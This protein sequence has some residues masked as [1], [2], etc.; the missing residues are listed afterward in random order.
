[1]IKRKIEQKIKD[2]L[3]KGKLIVLYGPRQAGKT[4]LAKDILKDYGDES[5][6]VNCDEPDVSRAL[7]DKTSTELR[8]FLG[9]YKL[10]VIDEAQRVR[11]IGLTLKLLVDT[12]PEMQI[13]ATGSSSFEL[14]NKINE[15][16]TGR[17]YEFFLPPLSYGELAEA[18]GLQA[19]RRLLEQ[20]MIYGMY[21]AIATQHSKEAETRLRELTQS[22]VYKDVLALGEVRNP[23]VL[24]KL[25]VALALQ[26]GNEVSYT[27]LSRLVGVTKET[28]E[29]YIRILEQAFII[30]RVG[31]WSRNIRTELR[32]LRKIYFWDVGL[33]NMLIN[34]LNSLELRTDKGALWENFLIAERMKM[35]AGNGISTR[36]YFW[37][38]HTQ[39]E[40]DYLEEVGGVL[41]AFEIKHK[42]QKWKAPATFTAGYP[43]A[44]LT[45]VTRDSYEEF[46]LE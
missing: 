14:A 31:P 32:K 10:V 30:F 17:K 25:L 6:Y 44:T 36:P 11:D 34:N 20:R 7:Q 3:F 46:I 12:Y 42:T 9:N 45:L 28:V 2:S 43:D 22:Y 24:E 39:Q 23:E 5:H 41:H 21:P 40:I 4:T 38:T 13:I 19:T 16:L 8:A 18:E 15:P 33:R 27:E 29:K 26:V 1:M 35:H 37:R